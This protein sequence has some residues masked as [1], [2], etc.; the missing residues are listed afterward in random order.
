MIAGPVGTTETQVGG[1]AVMG[2]LFGLS[3]AVHRASPR[4]LGVAGPSPRGAA[5]G[6][7]GGRRLRARGG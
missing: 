2:G 1:G 6:E 7:A 5:G 3:T 4:G